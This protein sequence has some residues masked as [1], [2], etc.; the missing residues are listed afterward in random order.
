MSKGKTAVIVGAQFAF[1]TDC[2]DT[3]EALQ[4]GERAVVWGSQ[5]PL[6]DVLNFFPNELD[7]VLDDPVLTEEAKRRIF[8]DN[9]AALF[10]IEEGGRL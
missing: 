8:W 1:E 4:V 10:H 9:A 7:T 2:W 6:P 3:H 5:Y